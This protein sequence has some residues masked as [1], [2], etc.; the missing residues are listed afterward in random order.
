MHSTR[1]FS[2]MLPLQPL[3][4]AKLYPLSSRWFLFRGFVHWIDRNAIVSC[5]SIYFN[6]PVLCTDCDG[7]GRD[8]SCALPNFFAYPQSH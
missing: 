2:E 3:K 6:Y 5:I 8:L 1:M 4:T 7:V